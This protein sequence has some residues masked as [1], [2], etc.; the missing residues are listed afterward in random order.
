MSIENRNRPAQPSLEQRHQDLFFAGE[1]E[2]EASRLETDRI[3]EVANARTLVSVFPE[4]AAGGLDDE[5]SAVGQS[6]GLVVLWRH[7][8]LRRSGLLVT[9][10]GACVHRPF[11][12]RS[13]D[14]CKL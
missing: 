3:G 1:V 6:S 4:E 11:W 9:N 7:F 12:D 14:A 10:R 8:Y 5:V 13:N 2:E